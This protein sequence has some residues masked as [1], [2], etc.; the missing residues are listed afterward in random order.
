MSMTLPRRFVRLLGGCG[1][2]M[3]P[4]YIEVHLLPCERFR[5]SPE[6]F[7]DVCECGWLQED[8]VEP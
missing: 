5:P 8:H 7:D 1:T 2:T 3:L 4:E 6:W